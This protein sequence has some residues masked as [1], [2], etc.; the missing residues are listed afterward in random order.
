MIN[1]VGLQD[2][3]HGPSPI[4]YNTVTLVFTFNYFAIAVALILISTDNWLPYYAMA[5]SIVYSR[6]I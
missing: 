5:V 1:G 6:V 4:L 3:H 2:D